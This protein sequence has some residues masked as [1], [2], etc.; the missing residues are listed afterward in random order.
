MVILIKCV[1][2]ADY[3]LNISI[4]LGNSRIFMLRNVLSNCPQIHWVCDYV[5]IV[6]YPQCNRINWLSKRPR[7]LSL[8]KSIQYPWA[9]SDHLII[10]DFL[11]SFLFGLLYFFYGLRRFFWSLLHA[12][13]CLFLES[14]SSFEN[15]FGLK[16]ADI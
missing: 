7:T 5:F 4:K 8:K 16:F 2:I 11:D 14:K 1:A 10:V 9:F 6:G 12:S 3:E 13:V 15:T